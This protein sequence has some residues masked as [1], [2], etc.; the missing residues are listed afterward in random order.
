ME[1]LRARASL[2]LMIGNIAIR[3]FILIFKIGDWVD[4]KK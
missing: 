2:F 4:D 3:V 1:E